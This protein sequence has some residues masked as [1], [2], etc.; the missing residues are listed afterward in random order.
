M[1][2]IKKLI[3]NVVNKMNV[4]KYKN[5]YLV[6]FF[7]I[8]LVFF[9]I[10][11]FHNLF[12]TVS[13][14]LLLVISL[15]LIMSLNPNKVLGTLLCIFI[16]SLSSVV[17][18]EGMTSDTTATDTK[19]KT[20]SVMESAMALLKAPAAPAA[21]APAA[22]AAAPAPAS[23]TPAAPAS[24][25]PAS[26]AAAPATVPAKVDAEKKTEGF[27][28]MGR[29]VGLNMLSFEETMRPKQSNSLIN[30]KMKNGKHEPK[31]NWSGVNG[32]QSGYSIV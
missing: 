5:V 32:Y 3:R 22:P 17:S 7:L 20:T 15:I 13:G 12:D 30:M 11:P 21:P 25:T 19:P 10:H 18:R 27:S 4:E 14:R 9:I 24:S 23:S 28:S 2:E 6:V 31:P 26:P 29:H 16:F 1:S 8:M